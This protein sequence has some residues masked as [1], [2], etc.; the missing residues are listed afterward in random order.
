MVDS[1][2]EILA[3]YVSRYGKDF[4]A[5]EKRTRV[6][7]TLRLVSVLGA[8]ASVILSRAFEYPSAEGISILAGALFFSVLFLLHTRASLQ[9]DRLKVLYDTALDLLLRSQRRWN[10][11]TLTPVPE[12]V[13]AL[14]PYGDEL[15]L[16]GRKSLWE[17]VGP[18]FTQGGK[19]KLVTW[20]SGYDSP[21][22]IAARQQRVRALTPLHDWRLRWRSA[23]RKACASHQVE[24][25]FHA[26]LDGRKI[27]PYFEIASSLIGLLLFVGVSVGAVLNLLPLEGISIVL[28]LNLLCS[29]SFHLFR[30]SQGSLHNVDSV[31][32]H[33]YKQILELALELLANGESESTRIELMRSA[34]KGLTR[35]ETIA[36]LASLR[37]SML[38][39]PLLGVMQLE[40]FTS[41][42]RTLW[43]AR[44]LEDTPRWLD[45]VAEIDALCSLSFVAFCNPEWVYPIIVDTPSP[46]FEAVQLSNPLLDKNV[47]IANDVSLH[48]SQQLTSLTGSNMSGKSTLLRS[49][50]SNVHLAWTGAPVAATK[51]RLS[52]LYVLPS[53]RIQDSFEEGISHF[54]AEG[55]RIK[56]I[57]DQSRQREGRVLFLI[58][59]VFRGTNSVE[60][61]I[62][63]VEV[64]KHLLLSHAIGIITTHD[65]SVASA[66]GSLQ[67]A[68]EAH[69]SEVI[70]HGPGNVSLTFPYTLCPGQASTRNALAILRNL[71]VL[72]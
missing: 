38:Y 46:L 61:E 51:L 67:N 64:A 59:E 56:T 19:E 72:G 58:D 4:Y 30:S 24:T 12:T 1:A 62:A 16:F 66:L 41:G 26:L 50:G 21:S 15:N 18:P 36:S 44:F 6:L 68:T 14:L 63:S 23:T 52:L 69:M 20:L 29:V 28:L 71:G 10:E 11:V 39:V 5:S 43:K 45:T 31:F 53:I 54:L 7:S 49:I 32:F 57:L 13:R 65:T 2:Q 34:L 55:M 60:R 70:T 37:R 27:S 17:L 40:N 48:E 9:R 47:A 8:V 3:A 25:L 22:A 33:D 35:L 42:A